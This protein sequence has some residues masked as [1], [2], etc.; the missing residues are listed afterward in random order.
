MRTH[1]CYLFLCVMYKRRK[2]VLKRKFRR[3]S[4]KRFSRRR[5]HR[6]QDTVLVSFTNYAKKDL[7]ASDIDYS[8]F[9]IRIGDFGD[10]AEYLQIYE[11]Y[12]IHKVALRIVPRVNV[13]GAVGAGTST[14]VGQVG[15]HGIVR[16]PA[17]LTLAQTDRT[18]K[19][20]VN[21]DHC[22]IRRGTQPISAVCV[23]NI[24]T[25]VATLG[26]S[27]TPGAGYGETKYKPWLGSGED[28]IIHFTW[29]YMHN[30]DSSASTSV[31]IYLKIYVAFKN[32]VNVMFNPA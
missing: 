29:Q 14:G 3:R 18:W 22:K 27:G 31:D 21:V 16:C 26:G 7:S 10:A 24:L 8:N 17:T 15:Q 12:K 23:P 28:D 20:F 5:R 6:K 9:N 25:R 1:A 2:R 32:R 13:T 11:Q 4:F 19:N 30:F